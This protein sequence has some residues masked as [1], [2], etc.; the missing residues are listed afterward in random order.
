MPRSVLLTGAYRDI[1]VVRVNGRRVLTVAVFGAIA[2]APALANRLKHRLPWLGAQAYRLAAAQMIVTRGSD[3]IA[4]VFV[5][6]MDRLG[7]NMRL[8]SGSVPDDGVCE[9]ATLRG[10][11][12]VQLAR[13]LLL[14]SR[15]R[16]LPAGTLTWTPVRQATLEFPSKVSASGDGEDLGGGRVFTIEVEPKAVR[17]V[18]PR[19]LTPER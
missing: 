11:S 15:G 14:L 5:A 13:V 10:G 8:P 7:G 18:A 3:P 16:P 4:G 9:T 2:D 12:R 1:D 6:N 19:A 17:M